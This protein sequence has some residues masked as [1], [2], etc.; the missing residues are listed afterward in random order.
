M[1]S[2]FLMILYTTFIIIGL[3]K[4]RILEERLH[5]ENFMLAYTHL[6]LYIH[7]TETLQN[8]T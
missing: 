5:W 8:V 2:L 3:M 6:Y 4:I 1:D 7:I